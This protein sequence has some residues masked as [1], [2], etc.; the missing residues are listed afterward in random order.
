M[1]EHFPLPPTPL[2]RSRPGTQGSHA[3]LGQILAV[4]ASYSLLGNPALGRWHPQGSGPGSAASKRARACLKSAFLADEAGTTASTFSGGAGAVRWPASGLKGRAASAP[5]L[6]RYCKPSRHLSGQEITARQQSRSRSSAS[7]TR[8]RSGSSASQ[9]TFDSSLA[10]LQGSEGLS[11][12][13]PSSSSRPRRQ[14]RRPVPKG[15]GS[16]GGEEEM[17]EEVRRE[18]ISLAGGAVEAFQIFDLSGSGNISMQEFTDGMERFEFPWKDITGLRWIL[19]LF[20]LFDQ[21]RDGVI[22]FEELFPQDTGKEEAPRRPTTPDFWDQWCDWSDDYTVEVYSDRPALWESGAPDVE[23]QRLFKAQRKLKDE[24]VHRRW[25]SSMF[26]RLKNRGKSDAQC[27]ECI[28][29]HLPRGTGPKDRQSVH[30]YSE[31]EVKNCKRTYKDDMQN[32]IRVIQKEVYT[33]REQRNA[34]ADTR[35][36]LLA[37]VGPML[38]QHRQEE[39]RKAAAQGIGGLSGLFQKDNHNAA[40]GAQDSADVGSSMD[41]DDYSIPCD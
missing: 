31:L 25:M 22:D 33:M 13:A 14:P 6:P 15:L 11:Q 34:L 12:E 16:P 32:H 1:E 9:G 8:S 37:T 5:S 21:N 20:A 40:H 2:R 19:D 36:Q 4:P 29:Q 10:W 30:T 27:R 35:Q 18:L 41:S 28:A 23:L 3:A 7:G 26:R 38:L 17:R 39:E 24:A